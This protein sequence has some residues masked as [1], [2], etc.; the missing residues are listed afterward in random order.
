MNFKKS[1]YKEKKNYLVADSSKKYVSLK[2]SKTSK[3][4]TIILYL[5]KMV[6]MNCILKNG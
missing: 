2:K 4:Q 1:I 5:I 3:N 6:T